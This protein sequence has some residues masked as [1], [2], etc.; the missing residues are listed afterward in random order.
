VNEETKPVLSQNPAEA[1][2]QACKAEVDATMEKYLCRFAVLVREVDG[3][4]QPP[5]VVIVSR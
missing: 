2:E 1:R 3:M 4:R 5:Q